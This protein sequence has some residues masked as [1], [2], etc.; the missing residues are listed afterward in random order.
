M[1]T[2]WLDRLW[3][4]L[5]SHYGTGASAQEV[6]RYDVEILG[7]DRTRPAVVP[8]HA[9]P[10][11]V[12]GLRELTTGLAP[13]GVKSVTVRLPEGYVQHTLAGAAGEVRELLGSGAHVYVCG[14]GERMAPAVMSTLAEIYD[15]DFPYQQDVF[16]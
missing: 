8:A 3:A 4:T 7:E 2:A 13:A 16:A 14:D 1:A 15:R 6:S 12:L 9:Y 11:E 10:I 5:A